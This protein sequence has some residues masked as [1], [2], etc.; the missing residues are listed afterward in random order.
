M[1]WTSMLAVALAVALLVVERPEAKEEKEEIA[2]GDIAQWVCTETRE[3]LQRAA[4]AAVHFDA[5]QLGELFVEIRDQTLIY[6]VLRRKRVRGLTW[7]GTNLDEAVQYVRAITGLNYY[8]TPRVREEKIEDIAIDL[9]VK[10]IATL[11][12]LNLI[13]ESNG[14]A[15]RVRARVIWIGTAEEWVVFKVIDPEAMELRRKI[16]LTTVNLTIQELEFLDV[17]KT[18][19]IQTGFNIVVDPR[20]AGMFAKSVVSSLQLQD[21]ELS[22]VLNIIVETGGHGGVWTTRGNVILLTTKEFLDDK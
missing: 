13:T 4:K 20:V 7:E 10:D 9:E 1:R 5:K 8:I 12:L 16:E 22:T 17:V 3:A 15:W 6:D 18:L 21:V 19:Q 2:P 11:D 14:L